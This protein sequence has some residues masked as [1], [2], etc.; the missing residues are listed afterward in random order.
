MG[1]LLSGQDGRKGDGAGPSPFHLEELLTFPRETGV[2]LSV[3]P[4]Q[5]LQ[6]YVTYGFLTG[7][8]LT[9][10]TLTSAGDEKL[11]FTLDGLPPN[12]EF[13][14]TL[15]WK[16]IAQT[17][18]IPRPPGTFRTLKSPGKKVTF[19]VIADTHAY[20]QWTQAQTLGGSIGFDNVTTTVRNMA[21]DDSLDFIVLGG[22]FAMTSCAVGCKGHLVDGEF[23]GEG[24]VVNQTEADL[25]YRKTFSPDVLGLMARSKPMFW[26]LGN[27]D[28]EVGFGDVN[29]SCNHYDTTA[30]LSRN[31]RQR[32]LPR[33]EHFLPNSSPQGN[34]YSFRSGDVQVVVLDIL[35]YNSD[36]PMSPDEWTLGTRQL[37]W[38]D[39]TLEQSTAPFKFVFAEHLLGGLTGP[40][41]CYWYGRGQL[42][43][44]I[45]GEITSSFLGEQA[46][47]H[48]ILKAHDAQVF[49]TFHDHV[50]VYGEKP[51]PNGEGEGVTY[52]VG[53]QGGALSPG[54]AQQ[55]WYRETMDYDEDGVP[56]YATDVTGTTK[57][58][59]FRVTVEPGGQATF[60]YVRTHTSNAALN[61]TTVLS[62]PVSP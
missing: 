42:K 52:V 3:Y 13:T 53:G 56:E 35:R 57:R 8:N 9:T 32:Y 6:C 41:D 62:F 50:V 48:E 20:A 40:N 30:L 1:M 33:V 4:S 17:E 21:L 39:R 22:D 37:L 11:V 19:G 2:T 59:Y 46:L 24:T 28:G 16:R 7:P 49:F 25:R 23:A 51:G 38:L 15:W 34:Y 5:P 47:V 55:D 26:V 61:G 31:A 58:G 12:R 18:F 44:T 45:S 54:W 27:H 14:Y 43:S 10:P 29:G 36:Y 60:E